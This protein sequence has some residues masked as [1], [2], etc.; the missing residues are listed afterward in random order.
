MARI[1]KINQALNV[2][3]TEAG[4]ASKEDCY[5]I[6]IH[7]QEALNSIGYFELGGNYA[8]NVRLN[9]QLDL[10]ISFQERTQVL[11]KQSVDEAVRER[12]QKILNLLD[13]ISQLEGALV[14]ANRE[15][16]L[17]G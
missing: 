3:K 4:T 10:G 8:E 1:N 13:G 11:A 7:L 12:D 16:A 6:A 2:I 15:K 9:T 14:V 5:R 17:R